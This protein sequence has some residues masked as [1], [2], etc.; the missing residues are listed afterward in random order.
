MNQ[1]SRIVKLDPQFDQTKKLLVVG[2]RLQFVQIPEKANH[3]II[4]PY[5]NPVIEKLIIHVHV[6]A[7]HAGPETNLAILRQRF[8]LTQKRVLRKCLTCKR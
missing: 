2:G 3:Q 4:V 8:W 1:K 6:K 7:C 5:G